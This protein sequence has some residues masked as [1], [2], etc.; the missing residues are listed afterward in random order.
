M[1]AGNKENWKDLGWI[2]SLELGLAAYFLFTIAYSCTIENYLT[3]PFLLLFF[4]GYGYIATMSLL[5]APLR[6]LRHSLS[7]PV[8][9]RAVSPIA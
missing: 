7:L 3:T 6:R 5:Q 9:S 4:T 2:P 1:R 8:R